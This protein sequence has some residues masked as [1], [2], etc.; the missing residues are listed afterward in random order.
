MVLDLS[1]HRQSYVEDWEVAAIQSRSVT[2]CR[3]TSSLA[4][5]PRL[6]IGSRPSHQRRKINLNCV[7]CRIGR[8]SR[9]VTSQPGP[10]CRVTLHASNKYDVPDAQFNLRTGVEPDPTT[11]CFCLRSRA[12]ED[13][14]ARRS[15]EQRDIRPTADEGHCA[16]GAAQNLRSR[17]H[18][19]FRKTSHPRS[20]LCWH[21]LQALR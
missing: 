7:W 8:N 15:R 4:S 20:F 19:Y 5:S 2:A 12:R 14:K 18:G 17:L 10:R 11:G 6:W 21:F 16:I 13:C 9:H 1:V 3:P